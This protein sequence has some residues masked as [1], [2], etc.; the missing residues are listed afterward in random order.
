MR[1][2]ISKPSLS[3]SVMVVVSKQKAMTNGKS[4]IFCYFWNEMTLRRMWSFF[5]LLSPHDPFL[6]ER[7]QGGA[8]APVPSP[9]PRLRLWWLSLL[10][11]PVP[12]HRPR[13][14]LPPG[15]AVKAG[16]TQCLGTARSPWRCQPDPAPASAAAKIDLLRGRG[17]LA[18]RRGWST[19][20]A[21]QRS[22][23]SG[24]SISLFWLAKKVSPP[25]RDM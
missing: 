17:R 10:W 14:E 21:V 23:Q 25:T 8:A 11:S 22:N 3:L 5:H 12:P 18:R 7:E 1:S 13:R 16:Q 19:L 24:T 2:Y 6:P 15:A 4:C 9:R 20:S